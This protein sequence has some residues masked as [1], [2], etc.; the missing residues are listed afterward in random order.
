MREDILSR[1]QSRGEVTILETDDTTTVAIKKGDHVITL[2]NKDK[3][4]LLAELEEITRK[5]EK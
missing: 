1:L 2:S 5:W 4:K 3:D